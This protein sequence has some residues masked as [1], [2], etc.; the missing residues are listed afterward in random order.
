M[1][2]PCIGPYNGNGSSTAFTEPTDIALSNTAIA[3]TLAIGGIVGILS[4]TDAGVG[5]THTYEINYDPDG[6]FQIGGVS[7]NELQLLATVDASVDASHL[8]VIEVRDQTGASYVELFTITV[9]EGNLAPTDIS[10]VPASG[11]ATAAPA[12]YTDCPVGTVVFTIAGVDPNSDPM[13]FLEI[14]DTD[15]KFT[16]SGT[17]VEL[18]AALDYDADTS[19]PLTIRATDVPGGLTYDEAF[20]ITVLA[21]LPKAVFGPTGR[22]HANSSIITNSGRTYQR[23]DSTA[24]AGIRPHHPEGGVSKWY[25][26]FSA[27]GVPSSG[28]GLRAGVQDIIEHPSHGS[29]S[30]SLGGTWSAGVDFQ[31]SIGQ[32]AVNGTSIGYNDLG[33][34]L[35][36]TH[37]LCVACDVTNKLVWFRKGAGP[38]NNNVL[39]DPDTGVGGYSIGWVPGSNAMVP[40]MS[41][42][43][44]G[45][46][47]TVSCHTSAAEW[48][49][50]APSL[51]PA[52]PTGRPVFIAHQNPTVHAVDN[53]TTLSVTYPPGLY[54]SGVMD[55]DDVLLMMLA[56]DSVTGN[57]FPA[58]S[59]WTA[60]GS[61]QTC[62]TNHIS[63]LFWKRCVGGES[64]SFNVTQ[65]VTLGAGKVFS[66]S[67]NRFKNVRKTGDPFEGYASNSAVTSAWTSQTGAP[68]GTNRLG[69]HALMIGNDISSRSNLNTPGTNN[70]KNF[71]WNSEHTSGT[72][73]S[74]AVG[75]DV[76]HLWDVNEWVINGVTCDNMNDTS[77]GTTFDWTNHILFLK[78]VV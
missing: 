35:G 65:A 71:D 24:P 28:N 18:S 9:T 41:C 75:D 7:G 25:C 21:S 20:T 39:A 40:I 1:L 78:P 51:Y 64:G 74:S 23:T 62:A 26:E 76:T 6:K 55:A 77:L 70:Y 38:W 14:V 36:G 54:G 72:L 53:L 42:G 49:H 69:V 17:S 37:R 3:D 67:I 4:C 34:Q 5:D 11:Y 45:S 22:S 15:S 2:P 63:Q 43:S 57:S 33:G 19:H 12:I 27:S 48:L 68:S 60:V 31:S 30:M 56:S 13:T 10:L 52:Y 16:I 29:P 46:T 61:M 73:D 50:S 59:G 44:N 47:Y 66:A 58:P 8:V 32:I